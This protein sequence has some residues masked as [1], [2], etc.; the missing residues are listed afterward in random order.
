MKKQGWFDVDRGGLRQLVADRNPG[1][2]LAE[3]I[4]NAWDEPGVTRVDVK[5]E[6]VAGARSA[7]LVVKD[8]APEGFY[9]LAHAWTL[10][11]DTRKRTD[12]YARGRFCLGDKLVLALCRWAEITTTTGAVRFESDGTRKRR[13]RK[14][15]SGSV[16]E[17]EVPITRQQIDDAL[18]LARTFIPPDLIDTTI[19]GDK[20]PSREPRASFTC[21]L[22]VPLADADGVMRE[23][24]RKVAVRVFD[25]LR[26][27]SPTLYEMGLPVVETGDRWHV[28]IGQKVPLNADRD[29]VRPSYLRRVRAFVANELVDDLSPDDVSEAWVRDAT[30]SPDIDGDTVRRVA[31]LRWGENRVVVSPGDRWGKERAIANGFTIV[32]S[33]ELSAAEW[34][35]FRSADAV[36]A[37]TDKFKRG[38][39]NAKIL[40]RNQLTPGMLR[41]ERMTKAVARIGLNMDVRVTFLHSPEATVSADYTP[42]HVRFNVALLGKSW[43]AGPAVPIL[44]LVI[45]ELGHEGGG[46]LEA[47]YY[48][49]LAR[50]GAR[51]AVAS[52]RLNTEV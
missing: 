5:L 30:T 47:G 45:H 4:Q 20:L 28:D 12:P 49:T 46:H 3:L 34:E 27:E 36:P 48:D 1:F 42:G 10:F 16:F 17:A 21:T 24:R 13:R 32:G 38:T 41:V 7:L 50:I 25:T 22:P 6:P 52:D 18:S 37:T 40:N 14:T 51:L 39:A 44:R 35:Q 43:F 11:S 8:D 26:G 2:I 23:S 9:E 33:R 19:N 15:E 31:D 29:N